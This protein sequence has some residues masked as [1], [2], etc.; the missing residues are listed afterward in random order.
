MF[1]TT[2]E[3]FSSMWNLSNSTVNTVPL[4][5]EWLNQTEINI[6]DV[7]MW[8]E[9]YHIPGGLGIYA[10]WSPYCEFYIIVHYFFD[11]TLE[12]IEVE[13]GIDAWKRVLDRAKSFGIDLPVNKIWV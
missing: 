8:E 4:R 10:A 6:D 1:K 3:I 13:Q 2:E 11:K 12:F 9:I 5:K 7:E